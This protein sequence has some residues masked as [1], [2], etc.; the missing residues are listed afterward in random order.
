MWPSSLFLVL[1]FQGGV[2]GLGSED[3]P[4]KLNQ[5]PLSDLVTAPMTTNIVVRIS[6]SHRFVEYAPY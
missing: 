4:A 2:E 5:P 1:N 6:A 3:L